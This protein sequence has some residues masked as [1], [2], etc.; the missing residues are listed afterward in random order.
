MFLSDVRLSV[1]WLVRF[2]PSIDRQQRLDRAPISTATDRD[3]RPWA[4]GRAGDG[5]GS[6]RAGERAPTR[7]TADH[8]DRSHRL[9]RQAAIDTAGPTDGRMV[10]QFGW[11][12]LFLEW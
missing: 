12:L 5:N 1:H 2:N 8:A 9:R 3:D 4:G 6:G 7:P 10:G 11:F